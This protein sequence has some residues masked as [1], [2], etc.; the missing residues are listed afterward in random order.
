MPVTLRG[1]PPESYRLAAI[2]TNVIHVL[3]LAVLLPAAL[4]T[5]VWLWRRR[6][7]GSL[8]T[9]VLL[10]KFTTL[11]LAVLAMAARLRQT[12]QGGDI[13]EIALFGV[14]SAVG[15]AL[16]VAY[17]RAMTPRSGSGATETYSGATDADAS[18]DG[19]ESHSSAE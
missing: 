11:G 4:L 19:E 2:P 13:G 8:L 6:D 9:G 3:D 14:V 10:V 15:L 17:L 12:G 1:E 18:G 16:G 7:W 5:A